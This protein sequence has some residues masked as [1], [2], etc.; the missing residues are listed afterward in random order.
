LE[1]R[2]QFSHLPSIKERPQ[3]A[4]IVLARGGPKLIGAPAVDGERHTALLR[5]DTIC[6]YSPERGIRRRAA[7]SASSR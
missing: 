7:R 6:A 4:G 1:V 5:A 2:E 3:L